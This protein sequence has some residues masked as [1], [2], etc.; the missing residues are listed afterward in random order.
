[1]IKCLF[2][3]NPFT[4]G[5]LSFRWTRFSKI[6][7]E[8]VISVVRNLRLDSV[9]SLS[10]ISG[11]LP[12]AT[13]RFCFQMCGCYLS[14]G[15]FFMVFLMVSSKL[16]KHSVIVAIDYCLAL[17]TSTPTN[18]TASVALNGTRL[19]GIGNSTDASPQP[20]VSWFVFLYFNG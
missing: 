10:C 3:N 6:S 19:T 8:T 15:G 1:M 9:S 2:N 5:F 20:E 17:W 11:R 18:H 16:L 4:F 13:P 14:S 12:S 7:R